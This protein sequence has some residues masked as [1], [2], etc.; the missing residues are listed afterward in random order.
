M[1]LHLPATAEPQAAP[2]HIEVLQKVGEIFFFPSLDADEQFA[3]GPYTSQH[4]AV[5]HGELPTRPQPPQEAMVRSRRATSDESGNEACV[6]LAQQLGFVE[7]EHEPFDEEVGPLP[8][9]QPGEIP[10]RRLSWPIFRW[11]EDQGVLMNG[12]ER[13]AHTALDFSGDLFKLR[14]IQP[15]DFRW[16]RKEKAEDNNELFDV[17]FDPAKD[18]GLTS[19]SF[20]SLRT[21]TLSRNRL[22]YPILLLP[23]L[24]ELDLSHNRLVQVIPLNGLGALESLILRNNQIE[25][26]DPKTWRD[27]VQSHL[28]TL[29]LRFNR[30]R[31][32]PKV[33][34]MVF[35]EWARGTMLSSLRI[36]GNPFCSLFPEYHMLA[37]TTKAAKKYFGL[38]FTNYVTH[39][40]KLLDTCNV[41]RCNKRLNI[42]RQ[43][44]A[45][46]LSCVQ[47]RA[48]KLRTMTFQRSPEGPTPLPTPSPPSRQWSECS[49][50]S[51]ALPPPVT[52]KR[53]KAKLE[54][55]LLGDDL[56]RGHRCSLGPVLVAALGLTSA[57]LAW[58]YLSSSE[59]EPVATAPR[60][61]Y[62]EISSIW[63]PDLRVEFSS[64]PAAKSVI[65][66]FDGYNMA[67]G[68]RDDAATF[69]ANVDQYMNP[70]LYYESVGFGNWHTP[71]GWAKG[72]EW[73]YGMA[74]PETVFTQMLFFGDDQVATTTTYGS[75]LWKGELFGVNGPDQW[76]NL[77]ITD[78]YDI[79]KD[80]TGRHRIVYNFMMIDWADALRQ[81]GRP[82]LFPAKLEEGRVLPPS[83]NDGVPA[84]LSVLVQA[85]KRD[86][87]EASRLART[88]LYRDWAGSGKADEH[89]NKDMVFYGPA[90]IG[91]AQGVSTYEEHVL[92]PFRAAFTNR[93]VE[94][95][96]SCCEGNYCAVLSKVHGIGVQ[97]WLGLPTAGKA[98]AIR[99]AMHW[100]TDS[101]RVQEG[102]LS[103]KDVKEWV[104]VHE[105]NLDM[106]S[107]TA[108]STTTRPKVTA[109]YHTENPD[110]GSEIDQDEED[111][112]EEGIEVLL[113]AMQS[114]DEEGDGVHDEEHAKKRTFVAVNEAKKHKNLA[115]GY[116]SG[117][118]HSLGKGA[119]RFNSKGGFEGSYKVSIEALK[120]RTRCA[121]CHQVGHWH[122]ECPRPNRL[123]GKSDK[124]HGAHLLE[125]GA[126]EAHFLGF[127][128]FLRIKKAMNADDGNPT[129]YGGS[130]SSGSRARPAGTASVLSAYKERLPV[131]DGELPQLTGR[132]LL[133]IKELV[134]QHLERRAL[135]MTGPDQWDAKRSWSRQISMDESMEEPGENDFILVE[136]QAIVQNPTEHNRAAIRCFCG[137]PTVV[138][139]TR[140]EGRNRGRLFR[141]CP[142]WTNPATR[143]NFFSWLEHQPFWMPSSAAS[144]DEVPPPIDYPKAPTTPAM[145]ERSTSGFTTPNENCSHRNVTYAG[146]NAFLRQAKCRDCGK[147]LK[148][149]KV[150]PGARTTPGYDSKSPT[151]S[152]FD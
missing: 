37:E 117:A 29:D 48:A 34:E 140:K 136:N 80:E 127:D 113:N 112:P 106:R 70:D 149:E 115:R 9:T 95:L 20:A 51:T 1:A 30:L 87:G 108:A 119:G 40:G 41:V 33:L 31:V 38:S 57:G 43:S 65:R 121:N 14:T 123:S 54:Q 111:D 126:H 116:G 4:S 131:H 148:K 94:E 49:S 39:D 124:D 74:F 55:P 45:F 63:D 5:S 12:W 110:L 146:S 2:E 85:Q 137:Q 69:D 84:P 8:E 83:A 72:E 129:T 76:V 52:A 42:L 23:R 99:M 17:D 89:W 46:W 109:A 132:E 141:R 152:I 93:S 105:T 118:R 88:A 61:K 91:L 64:E 6:P 144:S 147:V 13:Y 100:R 28:R 114:L 19:S 97:N 142:K 96:Y 67:R 25:E 58:R 78:F 16:R 86:A 44:E 81:I 98:V 24:K 3:P 15:L 66:K 107:T 56:S 22:T 151:S 7:E 101:F 35:E 125:A 53:T 120:R 59:Q 21:L 47:Q 150:D 130:S 103:Q 50:D 77:R 62:I 73:N 18:V 143:C 135:E 133:Q 26:L 11:L 122:K 36:S 60:C 138:L 92:S 134:D 10:I 32:T 82:I 145:S 27:G 102:R 71:H 128:D 79:P 75:A 68:G 90:G 104:R 139:Q